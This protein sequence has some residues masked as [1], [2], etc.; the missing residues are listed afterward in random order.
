MEFDNSLLTKNQTE[1]LFSTIKDPQIYGAAEYYY[2]KEEGDNEP[3][4]V[5]A[6]DPIFE[7]EGKFMLIHSKTPVLPCYYMWSVLAG[8][9]RCLLTKV[10]S[11]EEYL[12]EY[13][14][15]ALSKLSEEGIGQDR[16]NELQDL[17]VNLDDLYDQYT[18]G[19]TSFKL[20]KDTQTKD[21][22]ELF[23]AFK[24][25]TKFTVGKEGLSRFL[26]LDPDNDLTI[27]ELYYRVIDSLFEQP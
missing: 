18:V 21:G 4:P 5:V 22:K 20:I 25:V 10:N 23:T 2:T 6:E 1:I 27:D 15:R 17:G 16:L 9:W 13:R 24:K 12:E 19:K 26:K 11:F 14:K 7:E 8:G 3:H